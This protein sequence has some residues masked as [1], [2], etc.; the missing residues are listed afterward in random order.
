MREL[1]RLRE[2]GRAGNGELARRFAGIRAYR[3]ISE[4]EQAYSPPPIS[5]RS[6]LAIGET[7]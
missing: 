6:G 3:A 5:N 1:K 2:L 7:A 4:R